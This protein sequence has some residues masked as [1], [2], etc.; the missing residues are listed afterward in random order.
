M[1][2]S[3]VRQ[4]A[5]IAQLPGL[6]RQLPAEQMWDVGFDASW[7][8]DLFGRVSRNVRAQ[9]ALVTSAE[10]GLRDVQVSVAAE[11]AR[12]YFE[13][14]GAQQQL[15]VARRN[16]D[17]QRRTVTLTKDRLAASRGTA[18]L[19]EL[20]ISVHGKGYDFAGHTVA[21]WLRCGQQAAVSGKAQPADRGPLECGHRPLVRPADQ[22]LQRRRLPRR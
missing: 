6:S 10:Y 4:Q 2:G 19:C 22:R 8:L 12:T 11:V 16:A 15:E 9:G 13:L 18:L 5:S 21:R 1:S 17:N 7:E 3:S 14:R 20:S